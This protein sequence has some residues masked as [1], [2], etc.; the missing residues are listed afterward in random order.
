M[1]SDLWNFTPGMKMSGQLAGDMFRLVVEEKWQI[2]Q[3]FNYS[4]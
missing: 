2:K 1:T 4:D 3:Q